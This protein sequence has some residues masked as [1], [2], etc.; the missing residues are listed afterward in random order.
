MAVGNSA[1]ASSGASVVGVTSADPRH[2]AASVIDGDARTFWLSTGLF[3]QELL[4][5]L[6]EPSALSSITVLS[7]HARRIAL[8]Y[9]SDPAAAPATFKDITALSQS[10]VG[11]TGPGAPSC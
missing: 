9:S 3:P 6:A 2:G 10:T 8:L 11:T 1:S 4:I 7:A 5:R